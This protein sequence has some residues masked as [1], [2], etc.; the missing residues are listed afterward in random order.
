MTHQQSIVSTHGISER[1]KLAVH[2]TRLLAFASAGHF[3]ISF[4]G[5]DWHRPTHGHGCHRLRSL[6]EARTSD[7]GSGRRGPAELYGT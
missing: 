2:K 4:G 5:C 3:S 6:A 7:R 1:Q